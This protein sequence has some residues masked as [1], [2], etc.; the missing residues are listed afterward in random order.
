MSVNHLVATFCKVSSTINP[1]LKWTVPNDPTAMVPKLPVRSSVLQLSFLLDVVSRPLSEPPGDWSTHNSHRSPTN[2]TAFHG[3]GSTLHHILTQL[4]IAFTNP[5]ITPAYCTAQFSLSNLSLSCKWSNGSASVLFNSFF[6]ISPR[7]RRFCRFRVSPLP[8]GVLTRT[9]GPTKPWSCRWWRHRAKPTKWPVT[10]AAQHHNM[11]SFRNSNVHQNLRD[12][13]LEIWCKLINSILKGLRRII[14]NCFDKKIKSNQGKTW[15]NIIICLAFSTTN[16]FGLVLPWHFFGPS[17]DQSRHPRDNL[18]SAS[19]CGLGNHLELIASRSMGAVAYFW[20][21][22]WKTP[23]T[24]RNRSVFRVP[25]RGKKNKKTAQ[26]VPSS[27]ISWALI[28]SLSPSRLECNPSVWVSANTLCDTVVAQ[29]HAQRA[30]MP[31]MICDDSG[32]FNQLTYIPCLKLRPFREDSPF[33]TKK[34]NTSNKYI[35]NI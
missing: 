31:A 35:I 5:S 1:L 24:M 2:P 6:G 33:Y 25:E 27:S 8:R 18:W 19:P 16:A 26:H 14:P 20:W 12:I 32:R 13:E 22:I 29:P 23:D 3:F 17:P 9:P 4:H 10:L 11:S 21:E 30:T 34:Q 15:N 7:L 28:W